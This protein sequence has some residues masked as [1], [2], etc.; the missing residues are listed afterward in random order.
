M[1]YDTCGV[2]SSPGSSQFFNVTH[3]A[4]QR[5]TLKSWEEPGDEATCGVFVEQDR[6]LLGM[7]MNNML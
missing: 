6:K 1:A 2:A 5:A 7:Q 3:S 4:F